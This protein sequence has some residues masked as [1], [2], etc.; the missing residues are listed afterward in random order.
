M[1]L[2]GKKPLHVKNVTIALI[3]CCVLTVYNILYKCVTI[4]RNGLC[5]SPSKT[6]TVAKGSR[7]L[8]FPDFVTRTQDGGRLS[9]L[10][11]GRLY[12]QEMLLVLIAVR[13][14]VDPRTIL[15]SE[16]Y[17]VKENSNDTRWDRTN[18]LP[19]CSTVINPLAPEL[20]FFLILAHS[21]YKMWI[22]QESN[23]LALWNKLHF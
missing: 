22:I 13:G 16:K 1:A 5:Q 19:I 4:Q 11:T 3:Y 2:G 6:W 20:F 15:R 21:V 12:P 7:T 14:W 23:E 8:R 17:Y 18:D 10:S 9:A